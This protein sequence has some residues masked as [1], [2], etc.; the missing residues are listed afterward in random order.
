[1]NVKE[2]QIWLNNKGANPKLIPDGI[3]G[4]ATRT[5]FLKV[6]T[7]KNAKAIT[8]EELL[9]VAKKLGD[10]STK[11]IKAVAKV[12][13]NGA[14]FDSTGLVKIL[15]ERHYFYKFA[16][17]TIVYN[18][19]KGAYLSFPSYGGYTIDADKNGISDSWDKLSYAVC[20]D[21]DAAL[22]SISIGSF[23]VMGKYYKLLGYAHPIDMLWDATQNEKSHYSMLVGYILNVA[24]IKSSFLKISTNSESN[25]AFCNAYNGSSYEAN[26]YHI[27]LAEAMK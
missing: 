8:E 25:R 20:I 7:N 16:K 23:Q 13:T 11:R 17:K 24:N 15:Y 2:L 21:P 10:T 14:S 26:K 1:M 22:Q 18:P 27:K 9:E 19:I 4:P 12:E 3:G 5:A 6:F